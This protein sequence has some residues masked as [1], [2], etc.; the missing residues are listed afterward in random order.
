M[1]AINKG[2]RTRFHDYNRSVE[3]LVFDLLLFPSHPNLVW[4]RARNQATIS[5]HHD[6]YAFEIKRLSSS[7]S[8]SSVSVSTVIGLPYL[9]CFQTF[10]RLCFTPDGNI[11]FD[12]ITLDIRH[13]GNL[14]PNTSDEVSEAIN[15]STF[16]RRLFQP[17]VQ[18]ENRF[19]VAG[20]CK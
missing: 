9:A 18:E 4:C 6:P 5:L 2:I 10:R 15:L 11:P 1:S 7:S 17:R 20:W 19:E 3:T 14:Y 16:G 13:R 8:S 12:A